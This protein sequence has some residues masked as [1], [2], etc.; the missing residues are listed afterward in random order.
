M[1]FALPQRLF[2]FIFKINVPVGFSTRKSFF[3]TGKKPLDILINSEA[4]DIG[5]YQATLFD[6]QSDFAVIKHFPCVVI[7][8]F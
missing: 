6:G 7:W 2:L 1:Y 5:G 4:A 8:Y 3:E